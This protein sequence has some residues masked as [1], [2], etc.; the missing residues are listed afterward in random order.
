MSAGVQAEGDAGAL[1]TG[2]PRSRDLVN[3]RQS[4]QADTSRYATGD[5]RDGGVDLGEISVAPVD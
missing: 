5:Q 2:E 3:A 4:N 1:G